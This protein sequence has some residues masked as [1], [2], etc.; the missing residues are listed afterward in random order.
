VTTVFIHTRLLIMLAGDHAAAA[1]QRLTAN[2]TDAMLL[3]IVI[4]LVS[5]EGGILL[6][7]AGPWPAGFFITAI[8]FLIYAGA[9]VL[10]GVGD[11]G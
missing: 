1:A 3:G 4:A 5:N 10:T 9:R 2:P 8:S 11:A 7:L 6:S